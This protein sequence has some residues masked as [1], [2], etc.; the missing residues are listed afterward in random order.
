M[1]RSGKYFL[2]WRLLWGTNLAFET[3]SVLAFACSVVA[4]ITSLVVC[5]RSTP[6]RVRK[7][8]YSA[9]EISEETQNGFR[10][11]SNRMITFQEEI[12]RER[13]S[14]MGDLQ[15]AER[16]RRQAAAKLSAV[17]KKNPQEQ[18]EPTTLAEAL[19]LFPPGDPQRL[20]LLRQSKMALG[21]GHA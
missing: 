3:L 1:V 12:T 13:E 20:K 7:A 8:A 11:I 9:V 4:M 19:A 16:K 18:G 5:I 21:E 2:A 17:D 15:E 10:A 14:A 6:Q